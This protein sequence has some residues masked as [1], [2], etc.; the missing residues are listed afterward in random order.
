MS[1]GHFDPECP[2]KS[3][4]SIESHIIMGASPF[5]EMLLRRA[6]TLYDPGVLIWIPI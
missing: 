4:G 2:S 5:I 3:K 1:E 6:K